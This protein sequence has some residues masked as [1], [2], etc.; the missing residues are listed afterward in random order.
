MTGLTDERK[1]F[2]HVQPIQN[3]VGF[4]VL[5]AGKLVKVFPSLIVEMNAL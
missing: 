3:G 4:S 1:T 5:R 2:L